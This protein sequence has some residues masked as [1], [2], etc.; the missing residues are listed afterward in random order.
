MK[1]ISRLLI[2]VMILSLLAG[3]VPV[4]AASIKLS[5]SWATLEKDATLTLKLTNATDTVK[6]TTSDKKVATVS[7][8]GKITAKAEGT[9]VIIAEHKGKKY[10]CTVAV[11]DSN[12]S[13]LTENTVIVDNDYITA[14]FEGAETRKIGGTDYFLMSV[15]VTNKSDIEIAIDADNVTVND[16]MHYMPL[17]NSIIL[18]RKSARMTF[19]ISLSNLS[20]NKTSEIKKVEFDLL[21]K[22]ESNYKKLATEKAIRLDF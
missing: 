2:L 21:I 7:K 1:K 17:G 16:E 3:A 15:Y 13:V 6:W 8:K 22:K 9:A 18:P 11:I 5:K 20:I 19:Q 14:T 10:S 4:Q 12:D